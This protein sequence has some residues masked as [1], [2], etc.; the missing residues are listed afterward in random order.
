[1]SY[2]RLVRS[3]IAAIIFSLLPQKASAELVA[4]S[5]RS[6][7]VSEQF[8]NGSTSVLPLRTEVRGT[9]SYETDTIPVGIDAGRSRYGNA[10]VSHSVTILGNQFQL[11][12]PADIFIDNNSISGI[13]ALRTANTLFEASPT[14]SGLSL[15]GH[16]IG[17]Q[18]TTQTVFSSTDL[19]DSILLSE[20]NIL[21]GNL[22][23]ENSSI[24]QST[25][26]TLGDFTQI[27]EPSSLML[28]SVLL[29]S[30]RARNPIW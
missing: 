19:P 26:Y 23:F 15:K 18:D 4:F 24:R 16:N 28:L 10:L 6:E 11:N 9:V 29:L 1:M 30:C 7:V 14:I 2:A 25:L 5:Y 12:G 13:D 22:L 27:P 20:F 3:L 8:S 21:N 17:L